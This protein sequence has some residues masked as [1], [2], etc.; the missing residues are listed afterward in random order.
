MDTFGRHWLAEYRGCCTTLLDDTARVEGLMR[1]A[2][3]A[4]EATIV[5]CTFHR[6]APQ[7][8]S[9]VVVVQESHLSIHTWPEVGYAA[10][11]IYTCGECLP[12][13]A[14]DVLAA[15]LGAHDFELMVVHRGTRSAGPSMVVH[16]HLQAAGAPPR[17]ARAGRSALE[18]WNP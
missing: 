14:H 7:G 6:F 12:E 2:A 18:R 13:A 15:G 8:V 11:D 3:V 1:R 5:G 17:A 9:G 4:A 16:R 10:V